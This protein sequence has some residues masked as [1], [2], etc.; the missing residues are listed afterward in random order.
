MSIVVF[1]RR[2]HVGYS[3]ISVHG[4]SPTI[5]VDTACVKRNICLAQSSTRLGYG[6]LAGPTNGTLE[7]Y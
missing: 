3:V 7:H 5:I 2:L 4:W 1:L 6:N